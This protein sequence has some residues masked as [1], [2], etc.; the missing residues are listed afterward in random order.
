MLHA[1]PIQALRL[2][3]ELYAAS[4]GHQAICC[5]CCA[6]AGPLWQEYSA[7]LFGPSLSEQLLVPL[8][9][10][11]VPLC[12]NMLLLLLLFQARYGRS[13]LLSCQA[14][15]LAAQLT[16]RCGPQ[17]WLGGRRS[18][19]RQQHSGALLQTCY[20]NTIFFALFATNCSVNCVNA[21]VVT[22]VPSQRSMHRAAGLSG[23]LRH[24]GG[25]RGRV[26]GGRGYTKL[27]QHS[28]S[29]RLLVAT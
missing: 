29:T 19:P 14:P 24:R 16:R 17:A 9:H 23:A 3:R 21:L 18:Q 4:Q 7:F 20:T 8:N 11:L 25:E 15:S 1:A 13:T 27:R 2:E 26:G 10:Q 12:V 28:R 5:C 22:A 6:C